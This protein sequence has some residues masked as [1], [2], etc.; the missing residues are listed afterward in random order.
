MVDTK[1]ADAL[2]IYEGN[3]DFY[4]PAF[5][6]FVDGKHTRTDVIR[7]VTQVSYRDSVTEIDSFEL[8]INNYDADTR[9][10]KYSDRGGDQDFDPGKKLELYMGYYGQSSLTK[11]IEG[12]ITQLRPNFPASGAPTLQVSGLN[13]LHRL[14]KKQNT[15]AYLKKTDIDIAKQIAARLGVQIEAVEA[16]EGTTIREYVLQDNQYDIIFLM[17][18]ARKIGYDI[19]VSEGQKKGESKI[20]FVP[21]STL[22]QRPYDLKYGKSLIQFQPTLTTK[23]QVNKVTVK[24]WNA[25]AKKPISVTVTRQE[26]NV[27]SMKRK[28]EQF[29]ESAFDRE[30]IIT[31]VPVRNETEAKREA[32]AALERIVKDMITG[33]GSTVGMPDLRAGT[34][35]YIRGIGERFSGRYFITSTTHS[36]NDSGYLTTFEARREEKE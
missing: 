13:L 21:S 24:G 31:N 19:S 12:E 5:Q 2:E 32:K 1:P 27:R 36:I 30:E 17:G 15:D 9:T 35:V 7:D 16:P 3:R 8:T 14:R 26:L 10:Y 34:V 20:R 4:V 28:D 33:S 18:R 25:V 11:M 23:D 6:V 22:K 29:I